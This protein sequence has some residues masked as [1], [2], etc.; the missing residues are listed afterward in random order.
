MRPLKRWPS[1]LADRLPIS[2]G[3][4]P[5]KGSC[6]PAPGV[7]SSEAG[8]HNVYGEVVTLIWFDQAEAPTLLVARTS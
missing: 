1:S 7:G 5:E 2:K 3:H 6:S 4:S 8:E